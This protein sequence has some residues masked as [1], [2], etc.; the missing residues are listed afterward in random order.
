[1]LVVLI[2]L[3]CDVVIT[4]PGDYGELVIVIPARNEASVLPRTLPR[5]VKQSDWYRRL[6]VVDGAWGS[7]GWA[8]TV[9][10]AVGGGKA[11]TLPA[12]PA[13]TSGG[14][15]ADFYRPLQAESVAA[16]VRE[17]CGA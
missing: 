11:M 4:R 9:V 6:V 8:A 14:L 7:C 5:L 10:A 2:V 13:P 15:E 3:V 1:M 12:A 16:T 17:L